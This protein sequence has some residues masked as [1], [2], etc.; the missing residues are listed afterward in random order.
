MDAILWS[1]IW[2]KESRGG[3]LLWRKRSVLRGGSVRVR[4]YPCWESPGCLWRRRPA[5]R[6]RRCRRR[7][8]R[9]RPPDRWQSGRIRRRF[10]S[11]VSMRR[12]SPTSAWR[13]SI[14]S[15]KKTSETPS[16]A[17]SLLLSEEGAAADTAAEVA[18]AAGAF[19]AARGGFGGCRGCRVG[20][21]GVGFRGCGFGGCG[22]CGGCGWGGGWGGGC[23]L[24]WGGCSLW[25]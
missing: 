18:E 23:C 14:S 15:T 9:H 12:K 22:G 16:Q 4:L 7:L 10:R 13:R 5:D 25:C 11:P 2:S 8:W 21:C 1:Q 20:G 24:S 6:Q 17:C 19:E 3:T